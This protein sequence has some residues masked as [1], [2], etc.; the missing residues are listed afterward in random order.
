M[1]E[2]YP[3]NKSSSRNC[4][5]RLT[6]PMVTSVNVGKRKE[7]IKKLAMIKTNRLSSWNRE[8]KSLMTPIRN[9]RKRL[10]NLQPRCKIFRIKMITYKKKFKQTGPR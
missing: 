8:S 5:K 4:I 6:L 7:T 3:S 1:K 10:L 2:R 9:W